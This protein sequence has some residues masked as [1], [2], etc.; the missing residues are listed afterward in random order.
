MGLEFF[1]LGQ[2]GL[3]NFSP[4]DRGAYNFFMPGQGGLLFSLHIFSKKCLKSH[5]FF[6]L[7]GLRLFIFQV[8]NSW[9]GGLLKFFDF[10]RG[11]SENFAPCT[12][13]FIRA[14]FQIVVQ[15][16]S[17]Q[18]IYQKLTLVYKYKRLIL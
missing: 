18:L 15:K 4:M 2:G 3:E 14:C 10:R 13:I 5:F 9:K 1:T 17:L 7:R 8:E 12:K 6:I 11:T 16:G